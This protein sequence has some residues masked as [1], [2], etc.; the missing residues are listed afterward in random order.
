M[1]RNLDVCRT[2][3]GAG[4]R[5]AGAFKVA[6]SRYRPP[7]GLKLALGRYPTVSLMTM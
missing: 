1:E 3:S 2:S 5:L 4:L 7:S 6:L